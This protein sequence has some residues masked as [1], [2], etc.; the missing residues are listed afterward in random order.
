M[1]EE[2]ITSMP[3]MVG[4]MPLSAAIAL[5]ACGIA[6]ARRRPAR[7]LRPCN[8]SVAWLAIYVVA[9]AAASIMCFTGLYAGDMARLAMF[10][11]ALLAFG[12][13]SQARDVLLS[14]PPV[15]DVTRDYR[16]LVHGTRDT[17]IM[18]GASALAMLALETPWNDWLS[19]ILPAS[20]RIEFVIVLCVITTL[21]FLGGRRGLGAA[22]GVIAFSIIG[23]AQYFVYGFKVAPIMPS[24]VLALGTAMAVS[25]NYEYVIN[26]NVLTSTICAGA[27]ICSLAFAVPDRHVTAKY[28]ERGFRYAACCTVACAILVM[29]G[30]FVTTP[31]YEHDAG[32][33]VDS[34]FTYDSYKENGFLTTFVTVAQGMI[35]EKPDG[36]T[37]EHTRELMRSCV[38]A[39]GQKVA[40][41][42]DSIAAAE[43][44]AEEKPC[45]IAIMNETFSDLSAF[46]GL[47]AGYTG[48]EFFNSDIG[49]T[50]T[51]GDIWV[52]VNGGGTCNSE[53]EFL[54]GNTMAFFG[55][56]MYPYSTYKFDGCQCLAQQFDDL[57]YVT[58]AIHP[59]YATNWNRDVVYRKMGFQTFLSID[60]FP[61]ADKVHNEVSDAATY[62]KMLELL[63]ADDSPQFIFDVTMQNHSGYNR[64]GIPEEYQTDYQPEGWG[65]DNQVA[66]LNEYLGVIESSDRAL[67][68]FLGELS[69]L[70]RP[71]VVVFFGDH[72]PGFSKEINEAFYDDGGSAEYVQRVY[73]TSYLIWANYDVA[74]SGRYGDD[75]PTCTAYLSSLLMESIGAPLSDYQ[76]TQRV[77]SERVPQL[78]MYGF[79]DADGQL[80]LFDSNEHVEG[81]GEAPPGFCHDAFGEAEGALDLLERAQYL[82]FVDRSD[83]S[84]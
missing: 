49:G 46:E 77:A 24:D 29:L 33:R 73:Q 76:V 9:L 81:C 39:Y 48:P 83:S 7:S 8:S 41:D 11:L 13:I 2:I 57:G 84:D 28:R 22:L 52:S 65:D 40:S 25:G 4:L 60:D 34:W 56:G 53:F 70:D 31:D 37:K 67:K 64:G 30:Y 72:Q 50:V 54:T 36:Y 66:A 80:Y 82:H 51:R 44:F 59:N 61:H 1:S 38:D 16:S 19:Q 55:A 42:P 5:V 58:T 3:G 74:G 10:S 69:Q 45:V 23:I 12:A 71:V 78:N 35:V 15:N 47:H 21:Y 32:V 6:M 17:A 18:L 79:S 75:N 63:E 43:Q 20:G 26:G 68:D 14:R 27:A 62:D